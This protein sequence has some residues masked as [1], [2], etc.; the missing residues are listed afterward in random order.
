MNP[1]AFDRY[2]PAVALL[3]FTAVLVFCMAAFQPVYLVLGAFAGFTYSAYLRGWRAA[4]RSLTWQLP[5]LLIVTLANPLF[6]ASG[7]TELFRLGL[8]AVYLESL[9]FGLCMGIMLVAAM[10]WFS[11]ASQVLTSDKVMSLFGNV[12]P[13][14]AL[15]LSMTMRLVPQQV[16]RGSEIDAVQRAT[17]A[18][19]PES[20]KEKG[21]S[22]LRQVSVLMGWSMEDSLETADAMKARGWGARAKR[23]TYRRH[24]FRARDAAALAVIAVLV[25]ANAFLAW[26]ACSQFSFYPTMSA[27]TVWWGYLP[28][29]AL[30]LLPLAAQVG[31][32]IRWRR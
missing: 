23:T 12:A 31:E 25:A 1:T 32:D 22:R 29:L 30:L 24:R 27:C 14:L 9:A 5:L 2:H 19:R 21:A 11:N 17:S 18:A 28:Y 6:S 16:R 13:T 20:I 3:Y 7:S 4:L 10:L 15:V 8:R 26:T